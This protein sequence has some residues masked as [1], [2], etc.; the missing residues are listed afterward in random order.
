[1]LINAAGEGHVVAAL[2]L[3]DCLVV[4]TPTATLVAPLAEAERVK[5]LV[6]IVRDQ[7]GALFS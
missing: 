7:R 3:R 6:A 1:V 5:E 2:G 4:A